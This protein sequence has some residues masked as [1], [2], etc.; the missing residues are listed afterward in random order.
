[1]KL[2]AN[3]FKSKFLLAS[4]ARLVCLLFIFTN[5]LFAYK[6]EESFWKERREKKNI[7]LASLPLNFQTPNLRNFN[8]NLISRDVTHQIPIQNSK[9][10]D[11]S[12]KYARKKQSN[13]PQIFSELPEGFLAHVNVRDI[14]S[15]KS[16][17]TVVLLED[18]HLNLEAQGHLSNAIKSFGELPG[19]KPIL[20]GLEG[21]HGPFLYDIYKRF[22]NKEVATQVADSFLETGDISGPAHA[23]FT[24]YNKDGR[25]SLAFWGVDDD[26]L[27]RRN[28]AAYKNTKP[29]KSEISDQ[30][31]KLTLQTG[32]E[33]SR[34]FRPGLLQ[35]DDMVQAYRKGTLSL[36]EYLKKLSSFGVATSLQA[37]TFLQAYEM[38]K[39]LN[40][41]RVEA[42]RS[43]VLERL[44]KKLNEKDLAELVALSLSYQQG[45][46]GFADYY[47]E[48]KITC[49]RKGIVLAQTPNFD[50][51]IRYVLLTDGIKTEALLKEVNK[52]EDSVYNLLAKTEAERNLI[53]RSRA[54]YLAGKLL[55]FSLTTEEWEE[56]KKIVPNTEY[57]SVIPAKAG[58][59]GSPIKTFGDDGLFSILGTDLSSFE[60]FY[61][62]AEA[63]NIKMVENLLGARRGD[64]SILVAGG[65]HTAGLTR[66]LKEKGISY[67]VAAPKVTKLD[68][69]NETHYLS[70]FDREKTPVE[71]IF[72]GSKLFVTGV[73]AG[74]A[75]P[76]VKMKNPLPEMAAVVA[77]VSSENGPIAPIARVLGEL[78][79]KV[80]SFDRNPPKFSSASGDVEIGLQPASNGASAKDGSRIIGPTQVTVKTRFSVGSVLRSISA[81]VREFFRSWMNKPALPI[82]SIAMAFLSMR[83]S[84]VSEEEAVRSLNEL[85]GAVRKLKDTLE[86]SFSHKQNAALSSALDRARRLQE[87]AVLEEKTDEDDLTMGLVDI[88]VFVQLNIDEGTDGFSRD[89]LDKVSRIETLWDYFR[90]NVGPNRIIARKASYPNNAPLLK[91]RAAADASAS[92]GAGRAVPTISDL[93]NVL[94]IDGAKAFASD[95]E[96]AYKAIG[97]QITKFVDLRSEAGTEASKWVD[98]DHSRTNPEPAGHPEDFSGLLDSGEGGPKLAQ[99]GSPDYIRQNLPVPSEKLGSDELPSDSADSWSDHHPRAGKVDIYYLWAQVHWTIILAAI[100][101]GIYGI[102]A[103]ETRLGIGLIVFALF[104]G[105]LVWGLMRDIKRRL[106]QR[107][108]SVGQT[109]EES[110][111]ADLVNRW[112]TRHPVAGGIIGISI[113]FLAVVELLG[114]FGLGVYLIHIGNVL[115]GIGAIV[116]GVIAIVVLLA[117]MVYSKRFEIHSQSSGS[118]SR[119]PTKPAEGGEENA[120]QSG[121]AKLLLWSNIG[122]ALL[123]GLGAAY[124][125]A[126][127]FG[128]N[129]GALYVG[130]AAGVAAWSALH[131]MAHAMS[132]WK[133]TGERP[134][135]IVGTAMIGV[136]PRDHGPITVDD[137]WAGPRTVILASILSVLTV[138]VSLGLGMSW[139][140]S[141]ALGG[142]L[143][144]SALLVNG[145][146]LL[147]GDGD[148]LFGRN[149]GLS[150]WPRFD[151]AS[152]PLPISKPFDAEKMWEKLGKKPRNA[153]ELAA[154]VEKGTAQARARGE[155]GFSM[156]I[157]G[158]FREIDLAGSSLDLPFFQWVLSRLGWIWGFLWGGRKMSGYTSTTIS[159]SRMRIKIK[160]EAIADKNELMYVAPE[161]GIPESNPYLMSRDYGKFTRTED[162]DIHM[163]HLLAYLFKEVFKVPTGYKVTV[164]EVDALATLGGMESSNAFA[165]AAVMIGSMLSGA[166]LTEAD[167]FSL[168]VKLENDVFRGLTGGQGHLAFILGGL[169]R[170]VWMVKR[171][172]RYAAWAQNLIHRDAAKAAQQKKE[173]REHIFLVQPGVGYTNGKKDDPGRLASLT[174]FLWTYEVQYRDWV[175]FKLDVE[176]V[177]LAYQYAEFRRNGDW[178]GVKRVTKR[179]SDIRIFKTQY[180]CGLVLKKMNGEEIP[181]VMPKWVKLGVRFLSIF[182][183]E[184][185]LQEPSDYINKVWDRFSNPQNPLYTKND[186]DQLMATLKTYGTKL[187]LPK[188]GDP[189]SGTLNMYSWGRA[190]EVRKKAEAAGY[191]YFSL[192]AGGKGSIGAFVVP[193][194]VS[195]EEAKRFLS[196]ECG[197][198][199]FN[200]PGGLS[201]QDIT[202][203]LTGRNPGPVQVAGYQPSQIGL[204]GVVYGTRVVKE[205]DLETGGERE[206]VV[207][208]EDLESLGIH[209]PAKPAEAIWNNAKG[210]VVL[211]PEVNESARH[212]LEMGIKNLE[213]KLAYEI[214]HTDPSTTGITDRIL[215]LGKQLDRIG[216]L[217]KQVEKGQ[218]N[219]RAIRKALDQASLL[220]DRKLEPA[221]KWT[222]EKYLGAAYQA[223]YRLHREL[224]FSVEDAQKYGNR[225][226]PEKAQQILLD[227]D[228]NDSVF[229]IEAARMANYYL[230]RLN[231]IKVLLFDAGNVLIPF[232][233][234][235][236]NRS[237]AETYERLKLSRWISLPVL[238]SFHRSFTESRKSLYDANRRGEVTFDQYVDAFNNTYLIPSGIPPL[239]GVDFANL[240][241]IQRFVVVDGVPELIAQLSKN[242]EIDVLTD[243]HAQGRDWADYDGNT[244]ALNRHFPSI[245]RIIRSNEAGRT[246]HDSGRFILALR[247][248]GVQ[249]HEVV[250]FDDVD[251]FANRARNLGILADHVVKPEDMRTNFLLHELLDGKWRAEV[252][253]KLAPQTPSAPSATGDPARRGIARLSTLAILSLPIIGVIVYQSGLWAAVSA[254]VVFAGFGVMMAVQLGV[255]GQFGRGFK[256]SRP[257]APA[258]EPK[259]ANSPET[260]E[261]KTAQLLAQEAAQLDQKLAGVGFFEHRESRIL[262]F[263]RD[264]APTVDPEM[265]GRINSSS[266]ESAVAGHVAGFDFRPE[267]TV[268]RRGHIAFILGLLDLVRHF[269]NLLYGGKDV[270]YTSARPGVTDK[271]VAFHVGERGLGFV[272]QDIKDFEAIKKEAAAEQKNR[273]DLKINIVCF[274]HG[275]A[276]VDSLVNAP[277]Q[278]NGREVPVGFVRVTGDG[279]LNYWDLLNFAWNFLTKEGQNQAAMDR[280]SALK[281]ILEGGDDHRELLTISN[282]PDL[283]SMDE[284]LRA[285]WTIV[286]LIADK[287]WVVVGPGHL[288]TMIEAAEIARDQA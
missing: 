37:D 66:L 75:H 286:T 218:I 256:R 148:V 133:R 118:T 284:R 14:Y 278:P 68:V 210:Q 83:G 98:P 39:S 165:V 225:L 234:E 121:P 214:R 235:A 106:S 103:G 105:V 79:G 57:T 71:K 102:C 258:Q 167:I 117:S 252:Q 177:W 89:L 182:T 122:A 129:A 63:R 104:V 134:R 261:M 22:P 272:P 15:A 155:D 17:P 95:Q 159:A 16:G 33:K 189:E 42:E 181:S 1:M 243:M 29:L 49:E 73:P 276:D 116:A 208:K 90:I 81:R 94:R 192:G 202:D 35:F 203:I 56:Y 47:Q 162:P 125:V 172:F 190:D 11:F 100:L 213:D 262:K 30:L 223:L 170:V 255:T 41:T 124:V 136:E 232:D 46:I 265:L 85:K 44:V 197:L 59:H 127:A 246:K 251:E 156:I 287:Q 163:R 78:E 281:A 168:A 119:Q 27:Y 174:N 62:S 260:F 10:I 26:N 101:G 93:A 92:N 123:L 222:A 198:H 88:R 140:L 6:P 8:P 171:V 169:Y 20:V 267:K 158:P 157:D 280:F 137:V 240:F 196:E 217:R 115:E 264:T 160:I 249:P 86:A 248:L 130:V 67:I 236:R 13:Q 179:Y 128:L 153:E 175:T 178:D 24:S 216:E 40:F 224:P 247:E 77:G 76:A 166:D 237:A 69:N 34:Q 176:K 139:P 212:D 107:Q 21:A 143:L 186:S 25:R 209:L 161:W 288:G 2:I 244:G 60:S 245:R 254:G 4:I 193:A 74:A 31:K 43:L 211:L 283:Y 9:L 273:P 82:A 150:I 3:T 201:S 250:F 226:T 259:P 126:K 45:V 145:L 194:G 108:T 109:V 207:G 184:P 7:E 229:R 241:Q 53:A 32:S 113:A 87:Y 147:W 230:A 206:Q 97:D 141:L 84:S 80:P 270:V 183:G 132:I 274:V 233:E 191:A 61:T 64:T 54:L 5:V 151:W 142:V 19:N 23:G 279:V 99:N 242:Y 50:E 188:E 131:E 199:E 200:Q 36:A 110:R 55:D 51:Y 72:S 52:L 185:I 48:L 285:F 144:I 164:M 271:T 269:P 238:Q 135:F 114:I 38:E 18:I 239:K 221:E 205:R 227:L 173:A 266:L 277:A 65:F 253:K 112:M 263:L 146:A 228:S 180:L 70:V 58:I 215:E 149:V 152:K 282:R 111:S 204:E 187:G 91:E 195:P 220:I 257:I 138:P 231:S 275:E 12:K 120:G 154:I 28:V 96:K 219:E 268:E